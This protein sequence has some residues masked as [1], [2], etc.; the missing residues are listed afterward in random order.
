[1]NTSKQ[2]IN[3]RVKQLIGEVN[4]RG[5]DRYSSIYNDISALPP[6]LKS[7]KL[8][9]LVN[10][11]EI[12]VIVYF[13]PQ[14]H[15]GWQYVPKQTLIFMKDKVVHSLASIWL[16][17]EPQIASINNNDLMYI[18]ITLI[19]LYGFLKIEA[20]NREGISIIEVEFNTVSWHHLSRPIYRMLHSKYIDNKPTQKQEGQGNIAL[21][22][23]EL[24]LKFTNGIQIYGLLPNETLCGI[25]F[26]PEYWKQWFFFFR[27]QL[28]ANTMIL[29]TTN[30]LIIMKEELNIGHGWIIAYIPWNNIRNIN[31]RQKGGWQEIEIIIEY[32]EKTDGYKLLTSSD[33]AKEWRKDWIQ[34]GGQWTLGEDEEIA[35]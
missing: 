3:D 9:Q 7:S 1:M 16:E 32:D 5:A 33:I 15:R 10:N 6:E 20:V 22:Q 35:K 18:E 34:F 28:I 25:I 26:Q 27:K 13:P 24:P 31:Q 23:K 8:N 29:R 21:K 19:L 11:D 2:R 17:S 12:K 30:Y 14:I 4:R